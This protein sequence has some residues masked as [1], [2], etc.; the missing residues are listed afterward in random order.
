MTQG[1]L[2]RRVPLT[3]DVFLLDTRSYPSKSIFDDDLVDTQ[4]PALLAFNDRR[5]TDADWDALQ[6]INQSSKKVDTSKIGKYGLG[7]RSCY[8][9][10]DNIE[11][12]S[13][14]DLAIF[15]PHQR[16]GSHPGGRRINVTGGGEEYSDQLSGFGAFIPEDAKY[17]SFDGTIVRLP[18]RTRHGSSLSS[19]VVQ[20]AVIRRLLVDFVQKEMDIALL[21]LNN[22]K[23]IEI[24]EDYV[25]PK[26]LLARVEV[27]D[28]PR[29][30]AET[31][32][33][34]RHSAETFLRTI[35]LSTIEPARQVTAQW[36]VMRTRFT[37]DEVSRQL[38]DR[39][40]YDASL[41]VQEEKL[42]PYISLASPTSPEGP[43]TNGRLFTYLPLP[44]PTGLPVHIHALFA[45]TP[46]RQHLR[47]ANE[48]GSPD[49]SRD[50]RVDTSPS[51]AG[52]GLTA[53]PNRTILEWN[54]ILFDTL[55]PH[56]VADLLTVLSTSGQ[57]V[58]VL[59]VCS[60]SAFY[61]NEASRPDWS[62]V[63]DQLLKLVLNLDMTIWPTV[64]PPASA[65][66][67]AMKAASSTLFCSE[68]EDFATINAVAEAGGFVTR[69]PR[70]LLDLL[71]GYDITKS[72]ILSPEAVHHELLE[73]CK[74]PLQDLSNSSRLAILEYLA[75]GGNMRN[76]SGLPIVPTVGGP[77]VALQ[78]LE[79][80]RGYR[81]RSHI[82]LT[83][84]DIDVFGRLA[85]DAI[86]LRLLS[87]AA[88]AQLMDSG[89]RDLNVRKLSNEAVLDLI[90]PVVAAICNQVTEVND[91]DVVDWSKIFWAWMASKS[92]HSLIDG[93]RHVPILP[94]RKR[95]FRLVDD[96]IFPMDVT[97][98]CCYALEQFCV[99]FLPSDFPPT[100]QKFLRENGIMKSTSSVPDL[101]QHLKIP[102]SCSV[103]R[104]VELVA[105]R[106]HL[107]L[108]IGSLAALNSAQRAV[109]RCLPLYPISVPSTPARAGLRSLPQ[110]AE[111]YCLDGD[112]KLL[113]TLRN[114]VFVLNEDGV[115]P[116]CRA[117]CGTDRTA[118]SQDGVIELAVHY[119][120]EQ[121]P[122]VQ[123]QVV[124]YCGDVLQA[125]NLA[126][127][128]RQLLGST[129]FVMA[130]DGTRRAPNDLY[131][132]DSPVSSI[133]SPGHPRLPSQTTPD[134]QDMVKTLALNNY[135][136][137][138]PSEDL[139]RETIVR[140]GSGSVADTEDRA[141]SYRLLELMNQADAPIHNLPL[142][143]YAWLPAGR[144]GLHKP[145]EC[146][147]SL[148]SVVFDRVLPVIRDFNFT[149]TLRAA[150][151]WDM[152]LESC[153]LA[154][155]IYAVAKS[156]T[157][158]QSQ[159]RRLVSTIKQLA[160]NTP[161]IAVDIQVISAE[162]GD[163]HWVPIRPGLLV[164]VSHAVLESHPDVPNF[165]AVASELIHDDY[166]RHFLLNVGCS[167]RQVRPGI[168]SNHKLTWN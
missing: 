26:H 158:I 77:F 5:F 154:R 82:L 58:D 43:F 14:S 51:S 44:I 92:R 148:N 161:N 97:P 30:E 28:G 133:L 120:T 38:T 16:F 56:T 129:P 29:T 163:C 61:A 102:E 164:D 49:K 118:I 72:R 155:Q 69:V 109:L 46:D 104:A 121:A 17:S 83:R 101:L 22:V 136:C 1:L 141:L 126:P 42:L 105:V 89:V 84:D 47:N 64:R 153:I 111:I 67:D 37:P 140:L 127:R 130:Q 21:F 91:S 57:V 81:P 24:Y 98:T 79:S 15:D 78:R 35:T 145:S 162:L 94:D 131:M 33:S 116:L 117:I 59:R 62:P 157:S 52:Q 106:R 125:S 18:L 159:W 156:P 36:R 45:L 60:C 167:E 90:Q 19:E 124:E 48:Q 119:M 134:E 143:D 40:R 31:F 149:P 115:L 100:A 93:L 88:A 74:K 160:S 76:I 139:F 151:K 107:A 10:T 11:I 55:I 23:I 132:P 85:P 95:G 6:K 32:G 27:F 63:F 73:H 41:D 9:I 53:W 34:I 75:Q 7:I 147:D 114:T 68:N 135:L 128:V 8:H 20:P 25:D 80:S 12:R 142:H 2:S 108:Q 99:S 110:N 66:S 13:G 123:R 87:A 165:Y 71:R 54:K 152:P 39:L 144:Q 166:T 137:S 150:L 103:H 65:V 112:V 122:I 96:G 4:G 138:R 86:D 168:R 50:R 3:D 113:P 70:H 146:R